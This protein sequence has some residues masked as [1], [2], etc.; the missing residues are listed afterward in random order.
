[1]ARMRYAEMPRDVSIDSFPSLNVSEVTLSL[2]YIIINYLIFLNLL[3]SFI[4]LQFFCVVLVS[5][6]IELYIFFLFF[7]IN[8]K[9]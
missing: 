9:T 1:M 6:D 8:K 4:V 7:T 5:L 3:T 2:I